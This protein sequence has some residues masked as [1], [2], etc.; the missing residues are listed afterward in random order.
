MV[1]RHAGFVGQREQVQHRVGRAAAGDDAG[2][3]VLERL[4][5]EDVARPDAALQ[6]IHH[7]RADAL[8][9]GVLGLEH[10][11]DA[12]A[13]ERRDAEELAGHR[14]RVGGEL[15]AAGAGAGAGVIFEVAQPRVAHLAGRVRADRFEHVLD[16]DVVALER[17]RRDRPAVEHDAR[18]VHPRQR[19]QRARDRLVAAAEHHHRVEVMAAHHQLDRV[20]DDLAAD[21]RG[22]HALGAHRDAVRHRD[23]VELHR[24]AA[25]LAHAFLHLGGEA[26]QVEVARADL[27]PRVGDAD[28]RLV[29][30]GVG[31]A[32]RLQHGARRGAARPFGQGMALVL[33][34]QGHETPPATRA[35][36]ATAVSAERATP[37]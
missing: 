17:A 15:A 24:R 9:D 19:H 10:R 21:E 25:G 33:G 1:E 4:A 35:S 32:D 18:Q 6:Q 29:Q 28:Q 16:R 3:R 8:G 7:Q 2:D 34:I 27:G 22:A 5:G 20:G 36:W 31:E 14:H 12:G 37:G 30:V 11:R 13:A 23:G 26:P